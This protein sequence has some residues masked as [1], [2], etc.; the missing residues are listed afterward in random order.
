MLPVTVIDAAL[1][2][3]RLNDEPASRSSDPI[4]K[5]PAPVVDSAELFWTV[6]LP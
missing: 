4:E 6:R 1:V 2:P 3:M 5:L